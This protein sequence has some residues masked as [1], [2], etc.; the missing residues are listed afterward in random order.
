MFDAHSFDAHYY[1]RFY[2]GADHSRWVAGAGRTADLL[3]GMARHYSVRV[4]RIVDLGAGT[5]ILLRALEKRFP[6]AKTVGVELSSHAARRYGWI[7]RSLVDFEDAAGF[8]LV[9]CHDVIQ[10][11][12]D[13]DATRAMERFSTLSRGMLYF[14]GLTAVDV[15]ETC[16]AEVSDL[17][18]RW[19]SAQWYRK[20]LGRDF[21]DVG[22]GV[23][24]L[25]SAELPVWEL[26]RR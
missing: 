5:G 9:V 4:R 6:R 26:E 18:G 17:R 13:A 10:Y 11:L 24:L 16:D 19:R 21:V 1:R 8:D 7:E 12:T 20:R 22:S 15:R 23:H 25:K 3:Y 14:T 2:H